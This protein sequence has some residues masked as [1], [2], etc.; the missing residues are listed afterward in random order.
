[1]PPTNT[2]KDY[3]QYVIKRFY[4]PRYPIVSATTSDCDDHTTVIDSILSSSGQ[5]TNYLKA[6]VYVIEQ[7][8]KADSGTDVND[9]DFTS[10]D[11]T[12][13]VDDG[14]QFTVDDA[15]QVDDEI[16]TVTAIATHVLTVTRAV[17]GTTA[18]THADNSDVY[19]IGP[20]LFEVARV[21]NVDFSSSTSNLTT[22][23]A[24]TGSMVSGTDYE[25]HYKYYPVYVE[26]LIG[27]VL[28][29]LE[30]TYLFPLTLVPDGDMEAG[31]TTSWTAD[32]G[33][34]TDPALSKDTTTVLHGRQALKVL[35][36]AD[37][38]NS[39][40]KSSSI[41]VPPVT[42]TL[43]AADVYISSGDSAKLTLYDVT[44]ST[45][46]E[47]AESDSTGWVHLEFTY[48]TPPT[49]E[50]VQL[51][52]E[53][54]AASDTT[55]WDN[56]IL[57]LTQQSFYTPPDEVEYSHDF[58]KLYY[59]PKGADIPGTNNDLATRIFEGGPQHYCHYTV[60]RDDTAVVP[61]R[62][63]LEKGPIDRPVW[64]ECDVDFAALSN[65]TTTSTAP[66][67]LVGQLVLGELYDDWAD[68]EEEMGHQEAAANLR[69]S[70]MRARLKVSGD[71]HNFRQFRTVT[72]GAL[73]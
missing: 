53:S 60:E 73:R 22:S 18:A 63:V 4:K 33:T 38:T 15:I 64:L 62:V 19:I 32:A 10:T 12:F 65:D 54:P 45:P 1:M 28:G 69:A 56:A 13:T 35:A 27:E 67:A 51:W 24:F 3:R 7:P 43:C 42:Q 2:R 47:T 66:L 37:A 34:G 26:D 46:L 44:N 30:V 36:N 61:L 57:L 16:M 25:L 8:T 40:A 41:Y 29:N 11:T 6:W 48:T 58:G 49:C 50:E 14:T 31:N 39:Y 5:D 59:Y 21:T 55:Y 71:F 70:A 52:L 68:E 23:P 17:Q 72:K 9:A 20:A